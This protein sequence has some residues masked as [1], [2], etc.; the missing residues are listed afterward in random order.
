MMTDLF[1]VLAS[2]GAM[3]AAKSKRGGESDLLT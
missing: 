3:S 1:V 2:R